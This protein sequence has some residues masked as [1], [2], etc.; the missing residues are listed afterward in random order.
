MA[1][2]LKNVIFLD[3]QTTG[4]KPDTAH[5][6][7]MAWSFMHGEAVHSRTVKLPN[8]ELIPKRIQ[9]ITGIKD[10]VMLAS[11]TLPEVLS[12]FKESLKSLNEE[13]PLAIIHFAQFERPF[14]MDAFEKLGEEMPFQILCTHEI[15]KRLFP[16]LPTRG[17]KGLAGY[18]GCPSGELK[19]AEGHV[20]ATQ[21]IWQGLMAALEEKGLS[22]FEAIHE[23]LA[24]TPK[25]ARGKYEYPLP[26][27]KRLG[28][29]KQPGVYRMLSRW[30]EI[31]YV[32][33]ATSLHDRVNSYFR[34]QKNRDSKKLEM[35]TQVWD[36]RVTVVGS[37]L[38]SALLETDEIKKWNPPYNIS[39]KVGRRELAFFNRDFTSMRNQADEEHV[40]GPFSNAMALDSILRLSLSLRSPSFDEHM[41]YEPLDAELL[42]AGF[43]LFCERHGFEPETFTSV[44]S[45][46]AVGLNWYRQLAEEAEENL[47]ECSNDTNVSMDEQGQEDVE[48]TP[49]DLADKFERHFIRSA[50]TYLR[51]KKL[52]ALLNAD[53]EIDTKNK[54]F[55]RTRNGQVVSEL[56]PDGARLQNP[57]QDSSID[58]YDRMT[59]LFT[60]LNKLKDKDHDVRISLR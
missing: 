50:A 52:T 34:G 19:R 4:A 29:P 39:L 48:L 8:D 13:K 24:E 27:E 56:N 49:E 35:L 16:N 58:T 30:G 3:L 9:L 47:E 32:G 11:K 33:K 51:T 26:K 44:R 31:L 40:I 42:K 25:T 10:E 14:L 22:T 53:I 7:E 38:E 37:P 46:L 15:A 17:I 41:F 5:I 1:L 20:Q 21:V 18:F 36:L 54:I 2:K 23:W 12:D 60:E 59:V 55:L 45:I 43:Q 28:L 6:L 57:W